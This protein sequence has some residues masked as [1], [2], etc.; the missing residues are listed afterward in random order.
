MPWLR[1]DGVYIINKYIQGYSQRSYDNSFV[2]N[3]FTE[4]LE[5]KSTIDKFVL[6]MAGKDSFTF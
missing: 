1:T 6:E 2:F 5:V 4:L 3:Y